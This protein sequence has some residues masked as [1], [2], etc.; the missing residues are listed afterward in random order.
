MPAQSQ[1][2]VR[3]VLAGLVTSTWS[4]AATA[5]GVPGAPLLYDDEGDPPDG[6]PGLWGRLALQFDTGRRITVGTDPGTALYRRGGQLFVQVFTPHGEGP[7]VSDRTVEALVRALEHPGQVGGVRLR[8]VS[9]QPGESD[10]TWWQVNV[11]AEFEFD[12]IQ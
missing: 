9:P 11:F 3:D 7:R 2:E 5:A 1:E 8:N 4:T 10:G 12:R 6:D